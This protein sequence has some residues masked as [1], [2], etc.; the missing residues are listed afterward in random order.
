MTDQTIFAKFSELLQKLDEQWIS[1]QDILALSR[2]LSLSS[3]SELEKLGFILREGDTVISKSRWKIT[4][5]GKSFTHIFV[6]EA[7]QKKEPLTKIVMTIPEKF[8][9]DLS[10]KYSF[11][12]LTKDVLL[13][14]FA[15]AK[16]SIKILNPY[17]DAACVAFIEKTT[18]STEIKFI[19]VGSKYAEKNPIL[20]RQANIAQRKITVKYLNE[21]SGTTQMF[22]LHAKIIIVDSSILYVGSANLKETSIFHNLEA[23][24]ISKDQE[25]VKRYEQ[26]YDEVYSNFAR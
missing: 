1:T 21:Y 3:L 18:P 16:T 8:K 13:D 15:N 11:I 5:A 23:G 7:S 24:I 25:L 9:Q 14:L 6:K 20:E 12:H 22:Q 10:G 26:V 4:G 17:I 19:T 2:G